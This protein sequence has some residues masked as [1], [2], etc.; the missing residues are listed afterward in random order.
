MNRRSAVAILITLGCV[1]GDLWPQEVTPSNDEDGWKI[2]DQQVQLMWKE[3]CD[4]LRSGDVNGA[5]LY[6]TEAS[7]DRYGEVFRE[8]GDSVRSLPDSWSEI[9][10]IEEFGNYASYSLIRTKDGNRRGQTIILVH[11]EKGQWL[12]SSL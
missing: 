9:E 7:R 11:D 5:V 2:R 12:L 6:F 1:P 8:M 10:M 3:F 4:R